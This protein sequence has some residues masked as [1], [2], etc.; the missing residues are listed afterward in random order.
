M[1][2][3][4][5][6]YASDQAAGT[7]NIHAFNTSQLNEPLEGPG[8]APFRSSAAAVYGYVAPTAGGRGTR[9]Y[10]LFSVAWRST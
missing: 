10:G 9:L 3:T 1:L 6:V 5:K 8:I 7:F 2:E 4:V